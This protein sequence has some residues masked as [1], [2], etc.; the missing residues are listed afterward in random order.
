MRMLTDSMDIF[1]CK[2]HNDLLSSREENEAYAIINP[3]REY[4]VYFPDGGAADLD[5][6]A[7]QGSL[8]ARWLDISQSRWANEE[9]MEGGGV[10]SLSAPG[11]GHWAV[12]INR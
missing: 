6:S 8:K 5:V 11:K 10:I 4:A 3:G 12:L 9:K 1:T 7:A 2:P